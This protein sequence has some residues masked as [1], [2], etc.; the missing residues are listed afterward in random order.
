METNNSQK[1]QLQTVIEIGTPNS[2]EP[3][4][5]L[6]DEFKV[7]HLNL[8]VLEVLA[9]SPMYNA[10]LDKYVESLELGK[11]R[12]AFIQGEMPERMKDPGLFRLPCRLGDSQPFDTL[13][14]LGSYGT[15][16]YP[17]GIVKNVE[18]H[19]GRLKLLDDFYII[20]M[21]KRLCN[22]FTGKEHGRMILNLVENGLMIW[23]KVEE[24]GLSPDVYSLVN[25]HKVTKEIWDRVKLLMKGTKLSLQERECKL[26]NEFDRFT[27]VKGESLYEYYLRFAQFI[28]DMNKIN[29]TMRP[30]QIN[31][32]FL[33]SLQPEWSK[34]VTDV[35]LEKDLHT[36][37]YDQLYSYL[38]Q[39]EAHDNEGQNVAG[40]GLKRNASG[41]GGNTSGQAKESGQVLDEE[42]LAF[43]ADPGVVDG[44]A[45]QTIITHSVAY[46]TDDLDAY[47]LDCDDISS[48][49]VILMA[50]LSSYDSDVLSEVLHSDNYHTDMIHQGVQEMQYSKQTY[51]VDYPDNEI[52]SDSNIIPY[53][54]YLNET[55]NVAIP[56]N[57]IVNE[58]LTAE[59]ERY[60]ERVKMFEQ[61]LNVDLSSREKFIDSQMDDMIRN[62]NEKFVAFEQDIDTLKPNLSKHVKEKESL[63]TTFIVFKKESK[64]KENKYMDKEIYLENKI[65]ELDNSGSICANGAYVVKERTTPNAITEGSWGFEHT[66]RVFLEQIIPFIN[67]LKALV[68]DFDKGLHDEI[69]EVQTVVNQREA[70]V[71]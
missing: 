10:I 2:Q 40:M 65:N 12:F 49:K 57:K 45:T 14:D 33:N 71:E 30:V 32:K 66:K 13:A 28:N 64:E 24:N 3:K 37:N 26:Y 61:R 7:L 19:V 34:L 29:I 15:N 54:Q 27:S 47:D 53:S 36:S 42:Q 69:T 5:T 62:K 11:N 51:F 20:D 58:S 1:N 46:Q 43:L 52:T 59:L 9:H 8:P 31:T 63:L 22:P 48:T 6:E 55:Q 16:S 41:S 35:K 56:E 70:T 4:Q 38:E 21:E 39:H 60:K 68:K 18:V 50:N 67:S 17:V 25:H 23:P 44:Q